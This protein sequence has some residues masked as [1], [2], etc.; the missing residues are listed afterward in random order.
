MSA[1]FLFTVT[2]KVSSV[3]VG[4]VIDVAFVIICLPSSKSFS[5]SKRIP[6]GS[7]SELSS[8]RMPSLTVL[9]GSPFVLI[10]FSNVVLKTCVSES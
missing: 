9:D 2:V 8:N 7:D 10:T 5:S 4:V 1:E 6:C 3:F